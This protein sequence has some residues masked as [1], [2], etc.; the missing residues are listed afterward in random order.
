MAIPG[1]TV[2]NASATDATS[3]CRGRGGGCSGPE[4]EGAC[5]PQCE[6]GDDGQR[7]QRTQP[8]CMVVMMVGWRAA[9]AVQRRA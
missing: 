6:G 1:P 2:T 5:G 7:P 8:V 3:R 9:V 4:A